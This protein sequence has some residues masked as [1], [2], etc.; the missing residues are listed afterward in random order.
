MKIV[1]II[2]IL[3]LIIIYR[4]INNGYDATQPIIG[5]ITTKYI[6]S[7]KVCLS[8]KYFIFRL[9]STPR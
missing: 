7:L 5:L 1:M 4:C 3:K 8:S 6:K 9:A 2:H